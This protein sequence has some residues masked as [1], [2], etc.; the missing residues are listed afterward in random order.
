[1]FKLFGFMVW[2]FGVLGFRG[3]GV[4]GFSPETESCTMPHGAI[5]SEFETG[6]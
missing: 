2:G 1:M 5:A 3:L 6:P 4:Y